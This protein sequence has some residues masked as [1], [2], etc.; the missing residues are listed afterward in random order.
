VYQ[1]ATIQQGVAPGA[2]VS[3]AQIVVDSYSQTTRSFQIQISDGDTPAANDPVD[4]D[5]VGF[6]LRGAISSAGT[7]R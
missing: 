3:F 4:N 2:E 1:N 7:D 6:F 5:R